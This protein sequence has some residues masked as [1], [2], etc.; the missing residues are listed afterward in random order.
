MKNDLFLVDTSV[1]IE[2]LPLRRGSESLRQ[3]VDGLIAEDRVAT[4]GMVLLEL[5]GGARSEDEYKRLR[6]MVS[7]LHVLG[8]REDTWEDASWLAFQT[9]RKGLTIPFT[10]LLIAT[11]AARSN[12]VVLHRDRHFDILAPHLSVQIESYV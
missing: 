6:S 1:W 4:T 8:V 3:R 7:A 5:L 10:D 12:A 2:V 9:R 11:V